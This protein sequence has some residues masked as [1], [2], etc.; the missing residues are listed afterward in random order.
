MMFANWPSNRP[1]ISHLYLSPN[2]TNLNRRVYHSLTEPPRNVK[3]CIDWLIALKGKDGEKN[4]K[5][6]GAALHK[7]L[8]DKPVGK[9]KVPAL[10]KIK[11]ITKKFLEKPENTR[12]LSSNELKWR[13]QEPLDKGFGAAQA[14]GL[15]PKSNYKNVIQTKG[16]TAKTV[17]KN[18]IKVVDGCEQFLENIKVPDHY[19]SAYSP[20]ATWDASCAKDVEAYAIIFMGV[21]P[22]LYAGLH[23]FRLMSLYAWWGGPDSEAAKNMPEVLKAVG[24][25]EPEYRAG[26]SAANVRRALRPVDYEILGI[27]YDLCG[28]WAFY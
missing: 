4:L 27:I 11:V 3:E 9:M 26:M 15:V 1:R 24:Y 28:F 12:L 25:V 16:V 22:M 21:A 14:F 10:E 23:C 2:V 19:K 17:S 5:A 7:I 20:E 18:L 8:A 6:L 13:F